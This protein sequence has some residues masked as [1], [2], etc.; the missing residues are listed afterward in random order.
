MKTPRSTSVAS[1][2]TMNA[3]SARSR[4]SSA[5]LPNRG[6]QVADRAST[7]RLVHFAN[8]ITCHRAGLGLD[9]STPIIVQHGRPLEGA[10]N[11]AGWWAI[12]KARR[13]SLAHG[14]ANHG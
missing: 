9:G 10:P 2:T 4:S 7:L 1:H 8:K 13:G 14:Q 3:V 11:A 6:S 5:A 12:T